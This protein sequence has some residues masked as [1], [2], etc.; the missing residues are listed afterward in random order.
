MAINCVQTKAIAANNLSLPDVIE[1]VFRQLQHLKK[2][3]KNA[4]AAGVIPAA[5]L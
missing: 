2:G 4:K 3:R 5:F 1:E